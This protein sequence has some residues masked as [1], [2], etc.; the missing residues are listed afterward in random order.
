MKIRVTDACEQCGH[1]T[2]SCTSNVLVHAEV[3]QYGMVVDPGCMKCMDCVSVC[4]KDALYYGFGKPALVVPTSK[5]VP[6]NY[7]LTWPEEIAGVL[8]FLG[9]FLAV[10]GVYGLVPFLMALGCAGI[11]T[12]LG[13]K[14][15]RLVTRADVYFHKYQLKFAG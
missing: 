2:A 7:S 15:W 11:S 4:P 12:F 5:A 8:L 1:C 6:K 9:S 3:K 14:V 13:L 10:R